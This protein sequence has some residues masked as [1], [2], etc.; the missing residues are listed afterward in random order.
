[1]AGNRR[2]RLF[3]DIGMSRWHEDHS[4]LAAIGH[5]D[6]QRKNWQAWLTVI[7]G[8]GLLAACILG[9]VFGG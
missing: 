4:V 9:R 1:M 8:L 3:E 6:L 7:C 5:T 2:P